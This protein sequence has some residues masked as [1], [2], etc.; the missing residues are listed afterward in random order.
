MDATSGPPGTG[1][2]APDPTPASG[3]H[4]SLGTRS[5]RRAE[6]RLA[7]AV[8]GAG[9]ALA[10]LGGLVISGDNSG[11]DGGFNRAPGT[12]L[13]A[14]VVA[15]GFAV[16]TRFRTGALGAAGTVAS[17]LGIPPLLVFLTV[18]TDRLPPYNTEAIL[19]VSTLAWLAAWAVGPGRGRP[20]YLGAALIGVWLSVL[21]LVEGLFDAPFDAVASVAEDVGPLGGPTGGFDGVSSSGPDPSTIGILSLVV[22]VAFVVIGRILDRSGRVG[23]ATPFA[24]AAF[25]TLTVGIL[26]LA[27]DLE[28]AGTGLLVLVVG[29]ALAYHGATVGRRATTWAGGAATALG[30]AVFMVDMT[31]DATIGGLLWL[32]AGLA[33]VAAGHAASVMLGETDELVPGV[34]RF[35]RPDGPPPGAGGPWT[36]A[37]SPPGSPWAPTGTGAPGAPAGSPWTPPAAEP[38]P[39][40]PQT[41]GPGAPPPGSFEPGTSAA[42]PA[43]PASTPPGTPDPWAPPAG[44]A[45]A[46]PSAPEPPAPEPPAA[47]P[48]DRDRPDDGPALP[49]P[50]PPPPP[51]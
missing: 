14:L 35:S 4:A 8:A 11:G 47:E 28:T 26:S 3:F 6:P 10:V 41:G 20:F 39:T 42:P 36:P 30:A 34:S 43:A 33:L 46:A 25:P 24:F 37:G 50:P 7:V 5:R 2:P 51:S 31:D 12:I 29:A 9:C 19:Y 49:P 16:L 44:P 22:G 21:Q 45:P 32:A 1:A 18:D 17:T 48:D 40:G 38:T 27:P 15:A 23:T 13:S